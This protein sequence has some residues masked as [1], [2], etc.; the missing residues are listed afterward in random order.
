VVFTQPL[1][2]IDNESPQSGP[3]HRGKALVPAGSTRCR[4]EA[5]KLD[6][7]AINLAIVDT[8]WFYLIELRFL[9]TIQLFQPSEVTTPYPPYSMV[10][11]MPFQQSL[12]TSEFQVGLA[13]TVVIVIF[14]GIDR[15]R[16]D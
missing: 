16:I 15:S 3:V 7:T 2:G 12:I 14:P 10:T 13:I 1:R 9:L 6:P 8:P 5:L 4:A 11:L